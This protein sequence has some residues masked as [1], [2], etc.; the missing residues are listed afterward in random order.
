[1]LTCT[2]VSFAHGSNDGQ[3]G[4]GLIMLILVGTVPTAYALNHA[5]THRADRRISG[6]FHAN[7]GILSK[8]VNPNAVVGDSRD[9]LTDYIRTKEFKRT[10]PC[11]RCGNMINE[12]GTKWRITE[13][14]KNVPQDKVRNFRNDMYV[15]SEALRLMQKTRQTA[16][17]YGGYSGDLANYKKH[18]D[19]ATKFIPDLGEGGGSPGAG[20]GHDDRLEAHRRDGRRENRQGPSHLRAGRGRG[21]HGDGDHR[22]GGLVRLAGEYHARAFLGHC[23]HHGGEPL[24]PAVGARCEIC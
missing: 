1:M 16:V 9:E 23:R 8:Y 22:S 13:Q 10:T 14:L 11:W 19:N 24:R 3:K 15:V 6:G 4:M 20:P 7:R 5:V 18:I 17:L 21:N 12:I 2:G